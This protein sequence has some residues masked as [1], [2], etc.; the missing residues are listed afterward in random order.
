MSEDDIDRRLAEQLIIDRAS[1]EHLFKK[2]K[3][4]VRNEEGTLEV[5]TEGLRVD[6]KVKQQ[7]LEQY[8]MHFLAHKFNSGEE[9]FSFLI[10][11][12]V[13]WVN[14]ELSPE[15]RQEIWEGALAER[16]KEI[17]H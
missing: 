6:E 9:D 10:G 12:M 13:D 17:V 7:I 3:L 14:N 11:E 8:L 2:M 16:T 5:D 15:Q 1:Y 4:I